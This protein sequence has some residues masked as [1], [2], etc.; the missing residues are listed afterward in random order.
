M[1][2]IARPGNELFVVLNQGI[3]RDGSSY[4]IQRTELTTKFGWTWRF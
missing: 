4:Q 1:R 3:D 2:W